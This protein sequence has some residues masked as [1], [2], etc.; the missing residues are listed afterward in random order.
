MG[1]PCLQGKKACLGTMCSARQLDKVS[2]LREPAMLLPGKYERRYRKHSTSKYDVRSNLKTFKRKED[3]QYCVMF[4]VNRA[5]RGCLWSRETSG[6][7]FNT[8][9]LAQKPARKPA[10]AILCWENFL[11][12]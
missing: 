2:A 9:F 11:L 5:T 7:Q 1:T 8:F 10:Q 12:L 3:K 4:E 6:W